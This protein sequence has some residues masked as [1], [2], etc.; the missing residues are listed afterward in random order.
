MKIKFLT[1]VKIGFS[2]YI[3]W[4][5]AAIIDQKLGAAIAPIANKFLKKEG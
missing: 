4:T 1:G 5:I 3:G 2:A